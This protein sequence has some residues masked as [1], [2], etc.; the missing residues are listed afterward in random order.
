MLNTVLL[1]VGIACMALALVLVL[2]PR[3][4]AAVPAYAA[5]VCLHLGYHITVPAFTFVFWGIATAMV[6][7]LFYISP[8]GEIDG[9]KASNFY[10]GLSAIA[11]CLL[12]MILN[13]NVMVLGTVLGAAVG[14]LAYMRTPAGRWLSTPPM[15]FVRY[16]CAK[17]LPAIVAVAI[18]GISI[19]GFIFDQTQ[20][21]L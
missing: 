17:A 19:E 9:N 20:F 12:G 10:V 8:R 5:M 15:N 21:R 3:W 4:V 13:V 2:I 18:I 6:L 11:G 1:I 14:L 16:F 7:G